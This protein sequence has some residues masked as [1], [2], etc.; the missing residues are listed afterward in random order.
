MMRVMVVEMNVRQTYRHFFSFC[1]NREKVQAQNKKLL[2][3]KIN[4]N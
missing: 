4:N 1:T 3:Y 2:N